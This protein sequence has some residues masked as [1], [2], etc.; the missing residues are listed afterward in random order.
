MEPQAL[1]E[2]VE[3]ANQ[4]KL[5]QQVRNMLAARVLGLSDVGV[6]LPWNNRALVLEYFQGLL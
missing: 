2:V 3:E 5:H 1:S 6:E 4:T